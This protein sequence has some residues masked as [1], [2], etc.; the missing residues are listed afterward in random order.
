[1]DLAA[2]SVIISENWEKVLC[3]FGPAERVEL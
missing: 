2:P 3:K 1:M